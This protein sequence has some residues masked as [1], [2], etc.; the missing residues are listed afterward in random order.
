M[1]NEQKIANPPDAEDGEGAVHKKGRVRERGVGVEAA[2][3]LRG[4]EVEGVGAW[5]IGGGLGTW[6]RGS[7]VGVGVGVGVQASASASV[8]EG[9]RSQGW[10]GL[11]VRIIMRTNSS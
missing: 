11:P 5:S 6:W 10:F 9:F 1:V 8:S 4:R 7:S 2:G 3:E